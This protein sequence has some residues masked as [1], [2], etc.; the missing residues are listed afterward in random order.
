MNIKVQVIEG[1]SVKSAI[2]SGFDAMKNPL[3]FIAYSDQMKAR[4]L[5]NFLKSP[6][7]IGLSI[8]DGPRKDGEWHEEIVPTNIYNR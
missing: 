7:K 2:E 6:A 1:A 5:E 8:Y 4:V 3:T